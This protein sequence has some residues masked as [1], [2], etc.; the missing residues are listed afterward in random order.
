[1]Y[2]FKFDVNKTS[3]DIDFVDTDNTTG[4]GSVVVV[5]T[6][7][8]RSAV[9]KLASTIGASTLGIEHTG[10]D[11]NPT[12]TIELLLLK[13]GTN[14]GYLTVSLYDG[15]NRLIQIRWDNT[16]DL[17]YDNGGGWIEIYD[18]LLTATWFIIRIDIDIDAGVNGQFDCYLKDSSYTTLASVTGIEFENNATTVDEIHFDCQDN[19]VNCYCLDSVGI[20]GEGYSIGD[21]QYA[22]KDFS[23]Y[24]NDCRIYDAILPGKKRFTF[25]THP[26]YY[27]YFNIG[28]FI[29]I[30]DDSNNL[31]FAGVI[32][33]KPQKVGDKYECEGMANEV[34]ERTYDKS[35]SGDDTD[36]KQK[37]IIDNALKFCY[38]STSIVGT[39]T[40]Y[41]YE[42]NRA[43]VYLFNL[44]RFLERQVGYMEPDGKL[45]TKA[46]NGLAASG[47][48]WTLGDGNQQVMLIDI[49]GL[50]E[51]IPGYY[52]GNT[53]ITSVSV[54]YKDNTVVV[55]PATP[56]ETFVKKRLKEFRDPKI[57]ELATAQQIGD[58]LFAIFALDTEYICLRGEGLGWLQPGETVEIEN[59]R[60]ITI[61]K[62]HR[63]LQ[64][65]IYDPK[66]DIHHLMIFSN[67]II[68]PR[69]FK[70]EFDTSGQQIHTAILQSFENESIKTRMEY[71][72]D[73]PATDDIVIGNLTVDGAWHELDLD[74]YKTVPSDAIGFFATVI[75]RDTAGGNLL[76]QFRHTSQSNNQQIVFL[77]TIGVSHGGYV[78]PI[79]LDS[80]HKFDYLVEVGM[81]SCTLRILWWIRGHT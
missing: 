74:T 56:S 42:Y 81:D 12:G 35:Y 3:T 63:L 64:R 46:Y 69:E 28:D 61:A 65:V 44:A 31:L 21:I 67:N 60:Q 75:I 15:V 58:N 9:L 33:T 39:T 76:C 13:Y 20:T 24:M 78:V 16:N 54:R 23:A 72:D 71:D 70:S 36:T 14:D 79:P 62:A 22:E 19:V 6:R 7:Y 18:S 80:N 26:T 25:T 37:D 45:W 40:T 1:M 55:R 68:T 59:T 34:F 57:Q 11:I 52:F 2:S 38:R 4:V 5:S 51:K 49:P 47:K 41:D 77:K 32:K 17:D 53:G 30:F 27:T 48:S 29:D 66:N 73:D 8:G 50:A 43:C 10:F